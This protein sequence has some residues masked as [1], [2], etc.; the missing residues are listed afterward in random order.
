MS[1][2]SSNKDNAITQIERTLN[3]IRDGENTV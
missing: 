1:H 2:F 3:N